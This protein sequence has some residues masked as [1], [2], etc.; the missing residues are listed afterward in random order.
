ML[1]KQESFPE[2]DNLIDN[3]KETKRRSRKQKQVPTENQITYY[4]PVN[5]ALQHVPN[6][7]K[8]YKK[9]KIANT[10]TYIRD[11]NFIVKIADYGK[12]LPEA[13]QRLLDYAHIIFSQK[14]EWRAKQV[15]TAINLDFDEYTAW[16]G[17]PSKMAKMRLR[18]EIKEG[19]EC[20]LHTHVTFRSDKKRCCMVANIISSYT[21][22]DDSPNQLLINFTQE[23]AS[24]T[25]SNF[26]GQIDPRLFALDARN[27]HLYKIGRKLCEQWHSEQMKKNGTHNRLMLTSLIKAASDLPT[28]EEEK[29]GGRHYKRCIFDPIDKCLEQ[30][31]DKGILTQFEW[32]A[33]G[34]TYLSDDQLTTLSYDDLQELCLHFEMPERP[35][36]HAL[37]EAPKA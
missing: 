14:T 29:T 12:P 18:K 30:L 21:A 5:N 37:L 34:G 26:I 8:R 15:E 17:A 27:P 24:Y 36:Q 31:V 11:D 28:L 33:R 3:K 20:L 23:Y 1:N 16:R 7:I 2:L 19:L 10:L 9:D 13:A 6:R 35:R 4:G 22:F 32:R 25:A